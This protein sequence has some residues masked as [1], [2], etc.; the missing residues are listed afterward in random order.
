MFRDSTD[1]SGPSTWTAGHFPEGQA[2]Y[3]VTGVS[4]YEASPYAKFAG[5][6]LPTMA[7]WYEA[8]PPDEADYTVPES[9]ISSNSAA[10][11]GT[12]QGVG[13]LGPYDMVGNAREWVA[14]MVDGTIHSS[15]AGRGCRAEL[16]YP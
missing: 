11:V 9:N 10:A 16:I 13:P 14:N 7:Q 12:S 3:P 15:W 4:W 8:A 2:D 5:K 1:R 6:S